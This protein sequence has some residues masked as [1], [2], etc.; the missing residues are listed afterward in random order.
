M[1]TTQFWKSENFWN[2]LVLTVAAVFAVGG[3]VF[4]TAQAQG[5]IM[6]TFG[7]VLGGNFLL[8]YFKDAKV[9][10]SM[11]D[12]LK[13]KNV[14]ANFLTVLAMILPGIITP[15]VQTDASNLVDAI[16][17]GNLQLILVAGF[18]F[19]RTIYNIFKKPKEPMPELA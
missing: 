13:S 16:S 8:N 3:D 15:D 19:V 12:I 4:P 14:W 11:L 9:R 1:K 2:A 18:Q 7:V 17:T 10:A 6:A 5:F